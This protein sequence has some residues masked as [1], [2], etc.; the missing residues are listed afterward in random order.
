MNDY[1][2]LDEL[3]ANIRDMAEGTGEDVTPATDVSV[4]EMLD[5]VTLTFIILG[6]ILLALAICGCVGTC[7]KARIFLVVVHTLHFDCCPLSAPSVFKDL[8]CTSRLCV[9]TVF[10]SKSKIDVVYVVCVIVDSMPS[11][12]SLYLPPS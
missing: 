12:Y 2:S 10:K 8:F 3:L 5:S 9:V 6:S 4:N 11:R 7:C 1:F